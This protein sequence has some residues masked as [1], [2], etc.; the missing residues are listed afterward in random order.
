M[1]DINSLP[2]RFWKKV[3]R[4]G[5]PEACWPWLASKTAQGYPLFNNDVDRLVRRYLWFLLH[6]TLP[7]Q[8]C[9]SCRFERVDCV[10]PTHIVQRTRQDG[11]DLSIR[12]GTFYSPFVNCD[13]DD[14]AEYA[15]RAKEMVEIFGT[16]HLFTLEQR[17]KGHATR[18]CLPG[19]VHA[20]KF[21]PDLPWDER[22][23]LLKDPCVYCGEPSTEI[24]HIQPF[25]RGGEHD[26]KNRAPT[27]LR[28]NRTK[29]DAGLLRFLLKRQRSEK[30]AVY[31]DH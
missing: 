18:G 12:R 21:W 8:F 31:A 22:K 25:S 27:C 24:D 1:P 7:K 5:G 17:Q 26:W 14:R 9:Y 2:D 6:G 28:C 23:I 16:R 20:A 30:L 15:A 19:G 3:D 29:N 4:S 11:M 13:P 10:N